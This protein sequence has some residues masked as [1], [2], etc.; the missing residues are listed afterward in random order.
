MDDSL[1]LVTVSDYS[2]RKA[3]VLDNYQ[4]AIPIQY[5]DIPFIF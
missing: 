4:T 1:A 2:T 5:Q 3:D